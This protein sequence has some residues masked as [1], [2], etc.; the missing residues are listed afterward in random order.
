MVLPM[1]GV[2]QKDFKEG[3]YIDNYGSTHRG[4]VKHTVKKRWAELYFKGDTIKG[5]NEFF[6]KS[7]KKSKSRRLSA[8]DAQLFVIGTDTFER[9]EIPRVFDFG[10]KEI[11]YDFFKVVD[12]GKINMYIHY[13]PADYD[14]DDK[15][16][17]RNNNNGRYTEKSYYLEK[18]ENL[19]Q[20]RKPFFNARKFVNNE[21]KSL[22]GD[23]AAIYKN[24]LNKI[25]S[26]EDLPSMIKDYNKRA[27]GKKIKGEVVVYR[28]KDKVVDDIIIS[29]KQTELGTLISNSLIETEVDN[30]YDFTV[31]V[32]CGNCATLSGT[33]NNKTYVEVYQLK[34]NPTWY[35][36]LVNQT[37]GSFYAQQ[38]E[39]LMKKRKKKSD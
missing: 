32:Q 16:F 17:N 33:S 3:F 28:R 38:I 31:C 26:F 9:R 36:K 34:N 15:P 20:V 23:D 2:S 12:K 24:W 13:H 25:Y 35:F 30:I 11:A 14:P 22:V 7:S 4:L 27:T 8:V 29:N 18:N 6:Y 39:Y 1:I 5:F 21:V 37:E 19:V 10:G